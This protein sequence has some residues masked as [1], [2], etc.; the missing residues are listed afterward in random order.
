MAQKHLTVF[1]RSKAKPSEKTKVETLS[2]MQASQK[3][4]KN[5][6]FRQ[7]LLKTCRLH[8]SFQPHT[9]EKLEKH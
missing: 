7:W 3:K 6:F 4:R 2:F 8:T 5:V 9:M 1:S